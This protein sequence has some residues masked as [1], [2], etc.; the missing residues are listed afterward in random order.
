MAKSRAQLYDSLSDA[1]KHMARI[2]RLGRLLARL[3]AEL[4]PS[5]QSKAELFW[6]AYTNQAEN[7]DDD[8]GLI[9]EGLKAKASKWLGRHPPGATYYGSTIG[10]CTRRNGVGIRRSGQD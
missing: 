7:P 8:N 5:L 10:W 3:P 9:I 2:P 4:L 6:E 1:G